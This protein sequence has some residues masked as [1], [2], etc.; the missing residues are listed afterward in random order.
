M[1][2]GQAVMDTVPGAITVVGGGG[3]IP[4]PHRLTFAVGEASA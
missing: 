3:A 2:I 4:A 1:T